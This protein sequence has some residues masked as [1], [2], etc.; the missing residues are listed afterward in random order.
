MSG[1]RSLPSDEN[2][3]SGWLKQ[4]RMAVGV[5]AWCEVIVRS[6]RQR[7]ERSH[8]NARYILLKLKRPNECNEAEITCVSRS[9]L[10]RS[11]GRFVHPAVLASLTSSL[12]ILRVSHVLGSPNPLAVTQS[13]VRLVI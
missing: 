12:Q 9:I 10:P 6:L 3:L 13:Y 1:K 2:D 8:N 11:F 5:K 7:F 4:G